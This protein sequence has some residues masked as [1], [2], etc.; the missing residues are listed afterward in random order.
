MPSAPR[1]VPAD[2]SGAHAGLLALGLEPGDRIGIWSPNNAEWTIT[3]YATAKAAL[4]QVNINPAYRVAELEYALNKA[5]C[6]ALIAADSF[7]SNDYLATLRSLAPEIA[8]CAPGRLEAE[9][10]PTLTTL[11]H[12]GGGEERGFFRFVDVLSIGRPGSR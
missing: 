12:I 3:Q 4:I 7:K 8:H 6:K 1:R 5:G 11:I 10:L 9:R 2:F